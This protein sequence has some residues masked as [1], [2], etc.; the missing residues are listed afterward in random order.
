MIADVA[1]MFGTIGMGPTSHVMGIPILNGWICQSLFCTT[2]ISFHPKTHLLNDSSFLLV[3]ST[4]S[5]F[6]FEDSHL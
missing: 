2:V 1:N 6:D 3:I 5:K 4:P